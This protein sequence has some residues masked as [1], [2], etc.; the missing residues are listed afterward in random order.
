[1]VSGIDRDRPTE[2][3]L[4]GAGELGTII[5]SIDWRATAL[6]GLGEWPQS[7]R[8]TMSICLNSRFPI[9]VYWGSEYLML[10][11]QSLVPMVG[12]KKHPQAFG[13]PASVV[14]AEIWGIIEPLLRHVRETGEATWSEDLMLPLAR[15]G[16]PEESY[17]TFTYSPI[18]DESGG[19]GGVFCAVVETTDQVIEGRRLR[20]LNALSDAAR[21]QTTLDACAHAATEIARAPND[22]PFALLYLRDDSGAATLAGRA[23]IAAG[24]A[25]APATIR[26]GEVAP[27]PF[28]A[29]KNEPCFVA[30][31]GSPAGARGAVILPL[32]HSG[33]G[34]RFGFLVAGL[35]P[36]LSQSASYLRFHKLL[37]ASISSGIASAAAYQEERKRAEALAEIDRAKTA[38][39]SNVSHEFRTPLTLLLGPTREALASAQALPPEDVQ[40][41]QLV[42]RNAQRLLTLV[43]T[44]LEFSR[45]EAGRVEASYEPIDLAVLTADLAS[46][47]RSAIEAAGLRLQ[48][49][50][51]SLAQPVYVDR[52]MW[53]KIILNLLSNA[54]KFTF[55]GEI[56]VVLRGRGDR[57]E[58]QV[59]DTGTGIP[60]DQLPRIFDRF[61]RVQ[62]A[63]SRTHEGTGIGLALVHEL[64]KLHGGQVSVESSLGTG[65]TFTVSVPFGSSHLPKDRVA[66]HGTAMSTALVTHPI[67]VEAQRWT[68]D[69]ASARSAGLPIPSAPPAGD[70][71]FSDARVLIAD[72]NADMR[73]YLERLLSQR[74]K[75]A[76]AADG[77]A[78][79]E[80]VLQD[81]PDLVLSDVMMPRLDGFGL[82]A[83]LRSNA[84]TAAIPVVLVSARAGEEAQVEGRRAGANDYLVKPFSAKEL[85]ARVESQ[86]AL[87]ELRKTDQR[88]REELKRLFMGA[89][90]FICLL[91]GPDHVFELAND[92]YVRLVGRQVVGKSVRA[93]LPE[94]EEQGFIRLLDRVYQTGEPYTGSEVR[95]LFRRPGQA[96]A[97][98]SWVTFTYEAFRDFAGRIDGIAVFGSDVTEMVLARHRMEALAEQAQQADRRKDEF[99]AMLGHE[100]R[101][102][103]APIATA[104]KLMA[105]R[106]DERSLRERQ[107]IERQVAHLSRLVDDLLDVSRIAQG[108]IH[109]STQLLDIAEIAAK[110][111]EMASPLFEHKAHQLDI[112][113]PRGAL[114]VDGDP[115]RL[116][117]VIG[118]LLTNAARYTQPRGNVRLSAA[119]E[120][121]DVVIR[122]QDDGIGIVPDMLPR[123][124]DLF[125]Q[126]PQA[127]D[128]REGGLGLGLAVVKNLVTLHGGSVSA[129][130]RGSDCGSEFAVRLPLL[131]DSQLG[132]RSTPQKTRVTG[133]RRRILVVDDNVDAASLLAETLLTMG[134]EVAVAH[135]GAGALQMQG[136]FQAEIGVLDL[137]LPV[138]DGYELAVKLRHA[139]PKQ[140]RLIAL[141]G[142]GQDQ[143]RE[144]SAQAGFD[145][146]LVKPVDIDHLDE[147]IA[148]L[149]SP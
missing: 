102:P 31:E 109:L 38:F 69:S 54:L 21:A 28:E 24:S 91:R 63:R 131:R 123:I 83:A 30:V 80:S 43:N 107:V 81:P 94:L 75:V 46:V 139:T 146:H 16:A 100:L 10:Y 4:A 122:V 125:V 51:E 40:R 77:Q 126:G 3:F 124:F 108:K 86:L 35:S 127:I 18:R 115:V 132:A 136:S 57:A 74:W 52:E 116:A 37:A 1:L 32:E 23:N 93:V 7:L 26:P 79:L 39:F 48:I 76:T 2:D 50:L 144:R 99:L 78:A 84:E 70:T 141:S 55:E 5:R 56:A 140:L 145:A 11:N 96:T 8:T 98:E 90:V 112:A 6:G 60:A 9:A 95:V 53:E 34:Q 17:F 143:D 118:N 45:I 72:D 111:V 68:R 101:N 89:P 110:A 120:G 19:V 149:D 58:L 25:L 27:W 73:D 22:V 148:K 113:V 66:A 103:L 12:P 71:A 138:M 92:A 87:G 14:L 88:H 42:E 49:Q 129:H 105:L 44:L 65:T 117:Q 20:L 62:G 13:Q 147:V 41:W 67:A 137:G 119:R 134:H 142:Y 61:H 59:T 128:R 97:T 130:S 104:V 114:F 121:D 29:V 36:M 82:L 85:L 15:T 135:D 106:G 33:G 133:R 47:F 64:V